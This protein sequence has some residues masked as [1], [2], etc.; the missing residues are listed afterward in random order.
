MD[1]SQKLTMLIVLAAAVLIVGITIIGIK[2]LGQP[3]D[4]SIDVS[5][6]SVSLSDS[7]TDDG[8]STFWYDITAAVTDAVSALTTEQTATVSETTKPVLTTAAIASTKASTTRRVTTTRVVK[9][10]VKPKTTVKVTTTAAPTTTATPTTVPVTTPQEAIKTGNTACPGLTI[11]VNND[12]SVD[13][14]N[15]NTK[16]YKFFYNAQG[17]YYYSTND[18]HTSTSSYDS[19]GNDGTMLMY[20]DTLNVSFYYNGS[21]WRFKFTKGQYSQLF[22]G[23]EVGIYV[24]NGPG[25]VLADESAC[26][27]VKLKLYNGGS[28]LFYYNAG[29]TNWCGAYVPGKLEKFADRSGMKSVFTIEFPSEGMREAFCSALAVCKDSDGNKF[30]YLEALSYVQ[31]EQFTYDGT[32]VEMVWKSMSSGSGVASTTAA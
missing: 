11:R 17:K 5:D 23:S 1:K 30:K 9:T 2:V 21:W 22:I 25:Y 7:A 14:L 10:T 24:N 13:F 27:S 4:A 18:N 6:E 26:P 8:M 28:S 16:K 31:G 12:K 3:A 20:H 29:Q 32:K 15:N 19:Q